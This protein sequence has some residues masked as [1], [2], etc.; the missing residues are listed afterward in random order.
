MAQRLTHEDLLKRASKLGRSMLLHATE[1]E[2]DELLILEAV[3]IALGVGCAA[4]GASQDI[5]NKLCDLAQATYQGLE[6][7]KRN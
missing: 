3:A 4:A 5:L 1:R 2:T 6:E 7:E